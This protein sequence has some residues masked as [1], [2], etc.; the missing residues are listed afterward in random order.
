MR[1]LP[2]ACASLIWATSAQAAQAPFCVDGGLKEEVRALM[3]DGLKQAFRERT[4]HLFDVRLRDPSIGPQRA[5]SGMQLAVRAYVN[6][7]AE[8]VQWNPPACEAR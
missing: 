6:S 3:L 7:R 8:V 2:A 4:V 1:T 5:V